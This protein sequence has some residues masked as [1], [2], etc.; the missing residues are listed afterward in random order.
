LWPVISHAFA[1]AMPP[2]SNASALFSLLVPPLSG[3]AGHSG[4]GDLSRL[5]V[6]CA[7]SPLTG[8]VT[9]EELAEENLRAL[10]DGSVHFGVSPIITEVCYDV[11][12]LIPP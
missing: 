12:I 8:I 10:R 2:H 6:T 9:A 5:G 4:A 7:D 1:E 3:P 11:L